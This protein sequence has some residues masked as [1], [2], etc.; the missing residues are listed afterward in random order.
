[1]YPIF[2]YIDILHYNHIRHI[3]VCNVILLHIYMVKLTRGDFVNTKF[4]II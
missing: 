2:M 4:Y 3:V 1:M